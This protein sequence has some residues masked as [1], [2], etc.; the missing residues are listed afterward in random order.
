MV[1]IISDA[2]TREQAVIADSN[3]ELTVEDLKILAGF[4]N[5][6]LPTIHDGSVPEIVGQCLGQYEECEYN[7]QCCNHVCDMICI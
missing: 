3:T 4:R 6:S 5:A 1:T 7:A 2:S